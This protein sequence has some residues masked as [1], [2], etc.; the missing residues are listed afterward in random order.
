MTRWIQSFVV[1][2]TVALVAGCGGGSDAKPVG[3]VSG[4]VTSGGAP[5]T[6][7]ELLF[8]PIG[9]P[10]NPAPGKAGRAVIK[11][12]GT[13]TVSTYGEG[14]GAV[15][16]QHNVAFM[17]PPP[18]TDEHGQVKGEPK[19][20]GLKPATATVEVKSGANTVDI[21]LVPIPPM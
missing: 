9:G 14:D 5:V 21:D 17:A 4:K 13:Y 16:G 1:M 12:D 15:V 19:F 18:E 11:S 2:A 8:S 20:A 6:A 7:G 3:K 10:K